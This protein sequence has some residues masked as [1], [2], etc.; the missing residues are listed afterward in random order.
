MKEEINH[1]EIMVPKARR[2]SALDR[3]GFSSLV[4][5]RGAKDGGLRKQKWI[6]RIE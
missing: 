2:L 5:E 4:G 6:I 3:L 1:P